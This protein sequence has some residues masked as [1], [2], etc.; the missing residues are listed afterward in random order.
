M[1][2]SPLAVRGRI[3][4]GG[5]APGNP[6]LL[7]L[8]RTPEWL[9]RRI[10]TDA[11]GYFG[12]DNLEPGSYAAYYYNDSQRDRIGYWRSRA[13]PVDASR[14]AVFPT[15]DLAQVG[16]QNTPAMDAR[17]T[18]PVNFSWQLPTQPVESLRFRVHS[19]GG[20]SFRLI[21]Q[22]AELPAGTTGYT[23]DGAGALESLQPGQRYFWGHVWDA[24]AAGE[25]GNLFQAIYLGRP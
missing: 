5:R 9:E 8:I 11:Q 19:N 22:S 15:I 6:V 7:T 20:R 23:W 2:V 17:M 21:F 25:G 3:L 10:Q 16:L 18:L 12:V 1:T 24:G 13:L 14:G 4:L